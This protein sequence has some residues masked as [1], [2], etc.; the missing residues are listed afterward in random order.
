MEGKMTDE[1]AERPQRADAL[2]NRTRL[3]AA[4]SEVFAERGL[5][6]GV[7]EVAARAGVGR[8]TLFR[9]FPTKEALIAAIVVERLEEALTEGHRL[10]ESREDAEILFTFLAATVDRQ[11]RTKALFEAIAEEFLAVPEITTAYERFMALVEQ[12]IGRGKAAGAIRPELSS[13]DVMMLIKGL[14]AAATELELS[15]ALLERQISL[16]RAAIC[17]PEYARPLAG[18]MPTLADLEPRPR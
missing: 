13:V 3:L 11:L 6:A 15:P 5:E 9:N 1:V 18:P 12:M 7:A 4:A 14:C 16:I 8:A 10:L 17:T 2:R